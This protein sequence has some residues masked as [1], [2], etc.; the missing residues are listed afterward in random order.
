M[1]AKNFNLASVANLVGSYGRGVVFYA[2]KWDPTAGALVMSQLGVTEGDIVVTPNAATAGLT[3]TELTGP[4]KHEMD[5][6]GEDPVVEI[7]LF[8]TDPTLIA[9]VSPSGSQHGG[10]SRRGS[11]KEYTLAIFPEALFLQ[12]GVDGIVTDYTVS[13][14][15]VTGVWSFNGL[16]LTSQQQAYLDVSLWL[17]RVM[18]NRPPRRFRGGAGDDK[19]NIETVSTQ[20]M[21]HPDLP[22]GHHLFTTGDPGEFGIT[23]AGYTPS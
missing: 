20:T 10:R 1:T 23:L 17:W 2:D 6:L 8:L 19:K 11:V 21:H 16:A 15:D 7:P 4:A 13:Y 22:E 18:F 9:V 3:F 5:Y 14:D 12:A